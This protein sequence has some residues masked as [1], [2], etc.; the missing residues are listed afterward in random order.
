MQKVS[1]E[2]ERKW[3][4]EN[5]GRGYLYNNVISGKLKTKIIFCWNKGNVSIN[6]VGSVG[7]TVGATGSDL[8]P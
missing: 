5:G 2:E 6:C 3:D 4:K 7:I 1:R 8:T